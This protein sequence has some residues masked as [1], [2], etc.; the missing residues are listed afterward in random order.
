[1]DKNEVNK[2]FSVGNTFHQV[3][4]HAQIFCIYCRWHELG[5]RLN[6]E[7]IWKQKKNGKTM[8]SLMELVYCL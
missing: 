7:P 8:R 4:M 5:L 6:Q 3:M 2:H 1:M